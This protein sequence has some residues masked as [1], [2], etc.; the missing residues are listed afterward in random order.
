MFGNRCINNR[1]GGM[2]SSNGCLVPVFSSH[3]KRDNIAPIVVVVPRII[4]KYHI[5]SRVFVPGLEESYLF[6][7]RVVEQS[8]S[9]ESRMAFLGASRVLQL[10]FLRSLRFFFFLVFQC[11][12]YSLRFIPRF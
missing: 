11:Q 3:V 6:I 9:G 1:D 12:S 7:F 4:C 10:F 8:D 5:K 2:R